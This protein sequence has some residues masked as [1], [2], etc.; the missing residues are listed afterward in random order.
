MTQCTTNAHQR[1]EDVISIGVSRVDR[2]DND[3]ARDVIRDV[4][5]K[6]LPGVT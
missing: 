5:V 4:N 3:R 2:S 1:R 6:N